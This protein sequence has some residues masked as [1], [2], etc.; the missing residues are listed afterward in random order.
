MAD[1]VSEKY[2]AMMKKKKLAEAYAE[3]FRKREELLKEKLSKGQYDFFKN[4]GQ[5]LDQTIYSNL[6]TAMRNP[7]TVPSEYVSKKLGWLFDFAIP[8]REKDVILYFADRLQEYPYSDSYSRRSFRAKGNGAYASKLAYMI[9]QYGNANM[10]VV[11]EPLDKIITG[12]VSEQAKAYLDGYAWRGCGY[13]GWQVAYALDHHNSKVEEAVRRILTEENGSGMMT[14]ELIRGVVF[15]HRSDFHELL[16]KLLLAARL[17]EGLRQVICEN[18]DY[19]T[20]ACFLTILK[21]IAEDNLIRFSSVKRAVGTW[22]GILTEEARD[23]DRVSEKS[24]RLII[25]CLEDENARKKHLASEDAMKIYIALWSYGLD[26]IDDAIQKIVQ[27]ANNGSIH[28]LLVAG[29]FVANLDLP[30][31]SNQIAKI[32]LKKHYDKDEVLAVWL[33]CFMPTRVSALWNAIRNEQPIEYN[34]WFD[35]KAEIHEHYQL[36]KELY[37]AFSGK[38]KTFS[39]CV[40]PWYEAKIAKS[41]FAELLCTLTALLG[42]N[43]KIDEACGLIKECDSNQRQTY[44]YALLHNPKTPLQRKTVLE[45]LVDRETYTRKSAYTIVSQMKLSADEYHSIEEYLRFKGADIRKNVIELLLRQNDSELTACIGRLLE[46]SKEEVRLGGLDMLLQLKKDAKRHKITESFASILSQ[47]AK[48]DDLPSKE[49]I[50]LDSLVP[51]KAETKTEAVKLFCAEDKYLPVEFDAEYTELCAKTFAEYFPDSKLPE[52]IRGKKRGMNFF[53]KIKSA[54]TD[55][56]ACKS[57]TVAAM[58]ILSL[59]KLIDEHKRDPFVNSWGETVLFGNVPPH[60]PHLEDKDGKFVF[61]E[62]WDEWKKTNGITNARLVRALVLFKAYRKK[63]HFSVTCA[64]TIRTVFGAGFERGENLPYPAIIA[65]ILSHLLDCVPKEELSQL[66]SAIAIWFIGCV[67]DNMVMIHAPTQEKLPMQLEMA[68]L[69]A[70]AQLYQ[71]YKWLKCEN[72]ADLKNTFPLAVASAERCVAAFKKI[73]KE[74]TKIG[75]SYYYIG[76]S[77]IRVLHEPHESMYGSRNPL[78]GVNAYLFAAYQGIITKAQLFEFLLDA[79]NLR[80]SMETVTAIAST[81]YEKGKQISAHDS[82]KGIRNA[83]KVKEFL[84]KED[85]PSAEDIKIIEYV[86][87]IYEAVIPVVLASELSRGDSPATYTKGIHGIARIY[88]AKYL[89]EIL[90]AMGNDTL[91]RTAYYGWGEASNRKGSLSYLLSVCIPSDEDSVDTL[92]AALSGKKITTKRLIEAALF[93]PEWIPIIGKYL[94]IDSF[95]SV[96]YYFMAHMN[97]RFDDKRKAMIARFTPLSED[98]LNLGAFDVNWFHSAYDSIGEKEFDLIYDAAKYISDGAKH[99]RARKYADATLGKFGVDETEKTVSD[100]RN[101]DLLMAYALIPLSGEDDICRRYL[102]IQRFRKES[103]QFGSQR[104]ASE[105]KAVEMALTNLAINAGYSDTMRLTLRMETKVIDDSRALLEEQIIEGVSLKITLDENGKASLVCAKDGKTLK[106]VPAKLKKNE[107]V[108]ALTDMVKTLTEQYRRTRVMLERAMEDSTIFTFGELSALSAHP[109]V[110]PMLK[111]L[112]LISGDA[113]GFLADNGLVNDNGTIQPLDDSAKIKIAHPFDLYSKSCWRDY[114]KYL[115]QNKIAQPFRQVFRELYVKTAEEM[116]MFHSLRYAG[117]QIQPAKTVGALKSRRWV[118]DI[119]DGLQKVYYKENIV[120]QI[121]A[122]ADW[123]SPA[124]IEAP[125]LEWVCFTNRKTGEEIKI[126][127]IPDIV[128]SEVMRD[129]DLAVSVAHAGGVDP[130]TSHSTIE[131]RAA[132]L[133]FV[134]PMFRIAN[135]KVEG[136]HAIVDGKLAEYSIH[137]GS[138]VV[139]QIGAAMIPVLPVH[140]QHRGKIF[141]P[142]VDDDPKTAEII[143]KVLLFA[144]DDKIKDPMILSNISK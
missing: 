93:S 69:L 8:S 26:D 72:N 12:E 110:Y 143:S 77:R 89:S 82:Y 121:Y 23:L 11:D 131:M 64:E 134:L 46:N 15:S 127:D 119:E 44:F 65:M 58:D 28:Q 4:Q 27:I 24:V 139:H 57:A 31:L 98:E 52:L 76:D 10:N 128:F 39:P 84:G 21:V 32:V 9:R 83:R 53:D 117:N 60:S 33:P 41:D 112:V 66:A 138:G 34:T 3:K 116:D 45:G 94:E 63:T 86:S 25:D 126:A 70:H 51:A 20:K 132:I 113:V 92:R 42:D 96:C 99:S 71:I 61:A 43:E 2:E 144:E 48:A 95:E 36:I 136:H 18:A 97:E 38:T 67:P 118:A 35:S 5:F 102:Y 87:H 30:Y 73:P 122:L 22:L 75:N 49:K 19:G 101:K 62:L 59:S 107:T 13:T 111:N 80:E 37:S 133:S 130:E 7:S 79:D 85:E 14:N 100:K 74:E 129:V 135:V 106:S 78:V 123:F 140:S 103:R 54:L 114:Q 29:Y 17:Q 105:G 50:L 40:F 104:V 108:V 88:G 137:L 91:D 1:N 109:V 47:R 6:V 81:Y 124:D 120:A 16:G 90:S 125:T 56:V 142:F 115:F 55:P 68:H 141:L